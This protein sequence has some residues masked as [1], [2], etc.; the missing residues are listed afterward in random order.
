[1]TEV[2]NAT[3]TKMR[4]PFEKCTEMGDQTNTSEKTPAWFLIAR[5][6]RGT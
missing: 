2:I 3:A 6:A 4:S 1:M 5:V